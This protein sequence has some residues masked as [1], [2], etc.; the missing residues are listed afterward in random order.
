M[1]PSSAVVDVLNELLQVLHR[2]LPVYLRTARPWNPSD[3]DRAAAALGRMAA[4]FERYVERLAELVGDHGGTVE[5]GQFP[6][7]FTAAND[8]EATFLVRRVIE[9]EKRDLASVRHCVVD[10]ARFPTPHAL[11]EEILGNVQGHIEVLEELA[12]ASA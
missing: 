4:D 2:S 11:A 9:L 6:V 3:N 5:T 7:E 10:L 1:K 8:L 12:G